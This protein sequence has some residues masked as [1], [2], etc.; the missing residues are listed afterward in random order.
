MKNAINIC[1]SIQDN[2]RYICYF[3]RW[4]YNKMDEK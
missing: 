2:Y 4:K 3:T 1:F